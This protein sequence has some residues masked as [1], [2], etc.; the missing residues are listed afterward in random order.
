MAQ[1]EVHTPPSI[2]QTELNYYLDPSH[3][4]SDVLYLGTAG[5]YRLKHDG[6]RVDITDMRSVVG[7][8]E[9]FFSLDTQGFELVTHPSAERD[10]DDDARVKDVAYREAQELLKKR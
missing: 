1:A 4:G 10:Y 3:G 2:V 6:R 7:A 5:Y 9:G 8:S